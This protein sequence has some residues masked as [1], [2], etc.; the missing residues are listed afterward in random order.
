[1]FGVE[2]DLLGA[3]FE[4]ICSEGNL[5]RLEEEDSGRSTEGEVAFFVALLHGL[6]GGE[7]L[8]DRAYAGGSDFHAD[9]GAEGFG[10]ELGDGALVFPQVGKALAKG[11]GRDREEGAVDNA[12]FAGGAIAGEVET[13]VV[14]RAEAAEDEGPVLVFFGKFGVVE[15]AGDVEF[16]AFDE[17]GA[18]LAR[19]LK[20][21]MTPISGEDEGR[22]R[23]GAGAGL[24]LAVEEIVE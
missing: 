24:E 15:E 9:D 21:E 10:F 3:V 17:D 5:S 16:L 4:E 7:G 1:M 20:A 22:I 8:M 23:D 2:L 12:S 13:M 18:D 19:F 14:D 11:E 6:A